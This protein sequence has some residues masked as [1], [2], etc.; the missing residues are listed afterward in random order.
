VFIIGASAVDA[1][2]WMSSHSLDWPARA[3]SEVEELNGHRGG[4]AYLLTSFI[5]RPLVERDHFMVVLR[6]N[7]TEIVRAEQ[8][9]LDW[10]GRA[11]ELG[12]SA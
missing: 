1:E 7:L 8:D 6:T 3:V 4:V 5:E 9:L 10:I 2:R 11:R 12:W